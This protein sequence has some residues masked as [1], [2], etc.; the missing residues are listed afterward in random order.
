M[1]VAQVQLVAHDQTTCVLDRA[2]RV[3]CWGRNPLWGTTR[4]AELALPASPVRSIALGASGLCALASNG[5]VTCNNRR[6]PGIS[7]AVRLVSG[8]FP[9][10]EIADARGRRVVCWDTRFA[11]SV[12][13]PH[14]EAPVPTIT[15]PVEIVS[16]G[17][18][19]L[20]GL[21]SNRQLVCRDPHMMTSASACKPWDPDR[22]DE[23]TQ[24][25]YPQVKCQVLA[26]GLV[27]C[28]GDNR[29]GQLG[30]G[31][32]GTHPRQM[33]SAHAVRTLEL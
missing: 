27:S 7:G 5:E 19:E 2:G 30:T 29:F 18:Q 25:R 16:C 20:C 4:E 23:L 26:N 1:R 22:L 13:V 24:D 3:A 9:C 21:T 11:S 33:S 17:D 8:D 6:V 14:D 28:T 31:K 15:S 32:M 12:P 10:A